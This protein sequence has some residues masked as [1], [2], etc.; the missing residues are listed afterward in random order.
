AAPHPKHEGKTCYG[1]RLIGL[2][3]DWRNTSRTAHPTGLP[4]FSLELLWSWAQTWRFNH[5]NSLD[6]FFTSPSFFDKL[7]GTDDIRQAL[8]KGISLAELES[9]W[10]SAHGEFFDRAQPHFLY[11]W[12]S[13][14]PGRPF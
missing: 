13:P 14:V 2:A 10:A 1:Q 11:A 12:K 8:E 4:G 7:A 9:Q 3:E 5:G 6:G